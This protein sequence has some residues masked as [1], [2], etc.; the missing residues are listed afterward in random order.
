MYLKKI[1]SDTLLPYDKGFLESTKS[2]K[3]QVKVMVTNLIHLKSSTHVIQS[4]LFGT[5][6]NSWILRLRIKS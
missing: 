2:K 3:D 4:S 6:C 5:N 1:L